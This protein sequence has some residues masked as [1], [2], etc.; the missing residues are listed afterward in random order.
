MKATSENSAVELAQVAGSWIL[1]FILAML[2]YRVAA[3]PLVVIAAKPIFKGF[4]HIHCQPLLGS[5]S[6]VDFEINKERLLK[7]TRVSDSI[8][9]VSRNTN[10][11]LV[12]SSLGRVFEVIDGTRSK[13]DTLRLDTGST[14][15]SKDVKRLVNE[16]KIGPGMFKEY[17][18]SNSVYYKSLYQDINIYRCFIDKKFKTVDSLMETYSLTQHVPNFISNMFLMEHVE[19]SSL[20]SRNSLIKYFGQNILSL[21][22]VKRVRQK[23]T[24]IN[25]TDNFIYTH[26]LDSIKRQEP[27]LFTSYPFLFKWPG[28]V[29]NTDVVYNTKL[30]PIKLKSLLTHPINIIYFW[31]S[32]CYY[33]HLQ[34]DSVV[35][36]FRSLP[37]RDDS[38]GFFMLAS[39]SYTRLGK[40]R[41]ELKYYEG[42]RHYVTM[43]LDSNAWSGNG[44]APILQRL[45]VDSFPNFWV[46]SKSGEILF[47]N[48]PEGN[49]ARK[50]CED[51][52]RNKK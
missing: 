49:S 10:E 20:K 2:P 9:I 33:C 38:I 1:L 16:R 17:E 5:V 52:F 15:L 28:Y 26:I 3:K 43:G 13:G 8:V 4:Q 31:G 24:D 50:F 14:Q 45:G 11:I 21:Y 35:K 44:V 34:T 18:R 48:D 23:Y 51:Y 39:E 29:L 37:V 12:L 25:P 41:E 30:E 7:T 6:V 40:W 27:K 22:E 19:D 46:V 47:R 36:N 42:F 32:W